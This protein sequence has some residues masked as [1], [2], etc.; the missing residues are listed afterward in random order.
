MRPLHGNFYHPE[1]VFLGKKNE[2][3]IEA[4]ALD[5]LLREDRFNCA[6]IECFKAAL[7]VLEPQAEENAK[8]EVEGP[9]EQLALEGLTLSLKFG[10]KPARTDGDVRAIRNAIQELGCF[11]DGSGK[12]G[13]CKEHHI[14]PGIEHAIA[15]T[16]TLAAIPRIFNQTHNGVIL[17]ILVND[18]CRIVAGAI[19]DDDYFRVPALLGNVGKNLLESGSDA[20]T[21]VVS[22]NDDRGQSDFECDK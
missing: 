8:G 21:L 19:V 5:L 13:I 14:T 12:I 10:A 3:R 1:P 15:H 4:P 20:A 22:G 9:P 7:C 6:T 18:L 16:E 11:F 17:G 2:F